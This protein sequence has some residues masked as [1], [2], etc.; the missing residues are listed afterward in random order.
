MH[1]HLSFTNL[2]ERS[3]NPT[4]SP[5]PYIFIRA[6]SKYSFS[7]FI[8]N[9]LSPWNAS[10][11]KPLALYIWITVSNTAF[12]WCWLLEVQWVAVIKLVFWV[13][14]CKNGSPFTKKK[15][16][17]SC[18]YLWCSCIGSGS[19]ILSILL[20]G[21]CNLVIFPCSNGLA[22]PYIMSARLMSS[23]VT[24]QFL[25]SCFFTMDLKWEALG[26]PMVCWRERAL[27]APWISAL[28][29]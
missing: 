4:C 17:K 24:L 27:F 1:L 3:K 28:V 8:S 16:I 11:S 26:Q 18:K 9:S 20:D 29:K 19:G 5:F 14:V 10:I 21:G 13:F 7:V 15:S 22:G 25:S 12:I 6:G 23:T 2:M